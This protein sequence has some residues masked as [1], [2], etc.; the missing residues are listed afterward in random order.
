M[1][2]KFPRLF[3]AS[4][5]AASSLALAQAPATDDSTYQALGAQPGI[6]VIVKDFIGLI[7][8][9]ARI[10][11]A[12]KDSDL[13]NLARRLE[14]QFCQLSGGPCV[15]KGKDMKEIHDG[16]NITNAQFNAVAEHLQLAMERA[17][18]P[19]RYQFKLVARLAAMQRDIV[20]K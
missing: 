16:L 18:V 19:S 2:K 7:L 13:K 6:R 17:G 14:E 8:A 3:A 1:L 10:N 15:Y 9:D 4:L 11:E 20:T 5:L 12:F